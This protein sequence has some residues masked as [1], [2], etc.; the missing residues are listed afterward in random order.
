WQRIP[1]PFAPSYSCEESSRAGQFPSQRDKRHGVIPRRALPTRNLA[2]PR[3]AGDSSSQ[4]APRNDIRPWGGSSHLRQPALHRPIL[5]SGRIEGSRR[6]RCR[7][8][9]R[10]NDGGSSGRTERCCQICAKDYRVALGLSW[11]SRIEL[12]S[13][14]RQTAM[15]QTGLLTTSPLNS[16]FFTLR[17]AINAS[18]FSTS[19]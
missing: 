5:L 19:K 3:A 1:T 13:L 16:T 4:E 2:L 14:S 12:P 15:R 17:S 18:R 9:R 7:L 8:I 6:W 10:R 11:C